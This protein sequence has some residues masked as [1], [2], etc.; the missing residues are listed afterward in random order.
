MHK[1]ELIDMINAILAQIEQL[2]LHPKYKIVLYGRHLLSTI[3]WHFAVADLSKTWVSENLDDIVASYVR[4]WLEIPVC[5]TLSNVFPTKAKF[6]LSLYPPSIK[7]SQ[8]QT[9]A[10]NVLKC[11]PNEDIKHLW[12]STSTH[13]TLQYDL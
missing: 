6:G 5:G 11:S 13:I 8:C 9:V 1:S 7:F 12:K 2:P 4:K 10:S 3:S